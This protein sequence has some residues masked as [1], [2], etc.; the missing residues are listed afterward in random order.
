[1][2]ATVALQEALVGRLV[3]HPEFTGIYHDAP[4]RAPF[5]YVVLI[6]D[7]EKDW[8]CKGRDGR[9][10]MLSLAIWDDEPGR[11][12]DLEA[13][14]EAELAEAAISGRWHLSTFVQ[15]GKRRSRN[16]SGPDSSRIEMRARLIAANQGEVS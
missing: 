7:D 4:A 1:M 13:L 15:V 3:Q 6:C 8:S 12:L 9:E 16:P 5:P 10:I 11:L 14:V 2:G